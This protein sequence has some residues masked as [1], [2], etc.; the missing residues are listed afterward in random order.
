[1][2]AILDRKT[3]YALRA[4]V[5]L[6]EDAIKFQGQI[7]SANT[8]QMTPPRL[9]LMNFGNS[10]VISVPADRE[11]ALILVPSCASVKT[12]EIKKTPALVPL[13]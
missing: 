3:A 10:A 4:L 5:N 8:A 1:M 12:K 9:M 13:V 7:H 2:P 11:F 6:F